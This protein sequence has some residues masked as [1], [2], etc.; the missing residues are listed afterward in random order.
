MQT[1]SQNRNKKKKSQEQIW[2]ERLSS[3]NQEIVK[4]TIKEIRD[5]GNVKILPVVID[6][7]AHEENKEI[8]NEVAKLLMDIKRQQ[9]GEIIFSFVRNENYKNIRKE[10]LSVLW[11]SSIDFSAYLDELVDL[12]LSEPFDVAFEAFTVVEYI[13]VPVDKDVAKRN[14]DK[15]KQ[16][17]QNIEEQKKFLLVDL[18]DLLKRWTSE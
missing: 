17:I 4:E 16:N 8:K 18:V 1:Q 6:K 15:L 9:A 7:Y 10:L 13:S 3:P 2:Q 5:Y 12:F 14:I 11:Q